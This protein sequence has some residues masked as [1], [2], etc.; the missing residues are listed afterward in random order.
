MQLEVCVLGDSLRH[1]G[2]RARSQVS[3]NE[4]SQRLFPIQPVF[5]TG[6]QMPLQGLPQLSVRYRPRVRKLFIGLV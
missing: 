4:A 1:I 6:P 2:V 3:G 5:W